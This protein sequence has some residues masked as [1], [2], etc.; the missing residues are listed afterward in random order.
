MGHKSLA[1]WRH[2]RSWGYPPPKPNP[3]RG[4]GTIAVGTGP[5]ITMEVG[6]DRRAHSLY[7]QWWLCISR[8][9]DF[10]TNDEAVG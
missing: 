2:D 6:G 10:L 8:S 5:A 9:T 3:T 7:E 4:G 1:F